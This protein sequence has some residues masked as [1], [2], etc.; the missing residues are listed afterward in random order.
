MQALMPG[1][2]ESFLL[3]LQNEAPKGNC[4]MTT[5]IVWQDVVMFRF[6]FNILVE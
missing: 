1:C 6:N 4:N 3:Q 5:T 2:A